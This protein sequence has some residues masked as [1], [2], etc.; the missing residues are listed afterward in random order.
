[1]VP[2]VPHRS[3]L[4]FER[5][6]ASRTPD[7]HCRVTVVLEWN[8]TRHTAEVDGFDTAQGRINA[9]ARATLDAAL[10][11]ADAPPLSLV[12]VKAVRAFDGWVVVA[13]VTAEREG[14]PLRLLGAAPCE[15]EADLPAATARAILDATNRI[16][17][18][19]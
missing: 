4:R 17:R 9:A 16:L 15:A 12:G 1:M 10:A 6:D 14:E 3:R 19:R 2:N 7:G 13:R 5:V 18:P 11:I 8:D